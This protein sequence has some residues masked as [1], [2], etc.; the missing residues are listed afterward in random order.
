[1]REEEQRFIEEVLNRVL[2]INI[3]NLPMFIY[4]AIRRPGYIVSHYLDIEAS[5]RVGDVA[6]LCGAVRTKEEFIRAKLIRI[7]SW[8]ERLGLKTGMQVKRAIKI[9]EEYK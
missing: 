3:G 4:K 6:G 1:M 8:A 9:L 7:T 2:I 5:D